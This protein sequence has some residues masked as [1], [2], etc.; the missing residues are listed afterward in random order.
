MTTLS[1]GASAAEATHGGLPRPAS[2]PPD[3]AQGHVHQ[4][5]AA[6]SAEQ[7]PARRGIIRAQVYGRFRLRRQRPV[8]LEMEISWIAVQQEAPAKSSAPVH[9]GMAGALP[10]HSRARR[11]A[12][13]PGGRIDSHSGAAPRRPSGR[14]PSSWPTLS[15]FVEMIVRDSVKLTSGARRIRPCP[16]GRAF[17][18]LPVRVRG[19]DDECPWGRPANPHASGARSG[20]PSGPRVCASSGRRPPASRRTGRRDEEEHHGLPGLR[21]TLCCL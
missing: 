13:G 5:L 15:P 11:G 21:Q 3:P 18:P 2:S 10:C 14:Q 16:A 17:G 9:G 4:R 7:G 12:S 6:P 19:E 1:Q 8:E 20:P